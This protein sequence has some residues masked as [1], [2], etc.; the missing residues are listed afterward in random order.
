MF[1]A[2]AEKLEHKSKI[3]DLAD[4]SKDAVPKVQEWL[5]VLAHCFRLQDS[6]AVL[7][8]DRVLDSSPEEL[9]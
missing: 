7:E 1:D 2:L 3:G 8:L 9:S 4:A 6:L 5:A